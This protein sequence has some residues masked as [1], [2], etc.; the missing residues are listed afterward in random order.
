MFLECITPAVVPTVVVRYTVSSV[1][2]ISF[3]SGYLQRLAAGDA[4]VEEH[5][6]RY[7]GELIFIKLRARQFARHAIDDI[8]QETFLRVFQAI[9]KEGIRQPERIGAYVNSVC[10][11][12]VMEFSRAG[13]RLT[14]TDEPPENLDLSASTEQQLIER[15]RRTHVRKLLSQM[16]T[17]N[18]RLLTAMF[19]DER[20]PDEICREFGVDRNYLRVLL[21]RARTRLKDAL[22]KS[23]KG[24]AAGGNN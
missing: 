3:D 12:V 24:R 14:L 5:F 6:H 8:R 15:E 22:Q 9:R 2:F 16:S 18:Q 21:Y 10:N 1:E 4:A 17:K 7:F 23:G 20:H 11:N 13:S 19:L